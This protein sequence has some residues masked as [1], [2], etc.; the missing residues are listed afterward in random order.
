MSEVTKRAK[1]K[2]RASLNNQPINVYV[3]VL[4][5]ADL[6]IY[7][8]HIKSSR[9]TVQAEVFKEM[10]IYYAYLLNGV[11]NSLKFNIKCV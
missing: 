3:E 10:R 8:D 5:V 6:S 2:K 7:N 1:P 11:R 4:I 9:S